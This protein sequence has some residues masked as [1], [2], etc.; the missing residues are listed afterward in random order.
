MPKAPST[1]GSKT[2]NKSAFVRALPTL[3]ADEVIAK[4]KQ[5][6]ITL[7][8]AQVYTIRTNAKR[9]AGQT[10]GTPARRQGTPVKATRALAI[11]TR[12]A[13]LAFEVGITTAEELL[14]RVREAGRRATRA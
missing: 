3:S 14:R 1:N 5:A 13:S 10:A 6:G 8:K 12:L 4:G 2:V 11:E 7:S 9:K